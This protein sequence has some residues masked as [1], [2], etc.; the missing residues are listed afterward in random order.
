MENK[1][2]LCA[3]HQSRKTWREKA[4]F[5]QIKMVLKVPIRVSYVLLYGPFKSPPPENVPCL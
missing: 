1:Y 3:Y 5:N 4:V 2:V